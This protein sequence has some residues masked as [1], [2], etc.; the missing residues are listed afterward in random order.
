MAFKCE[1]VSVFHAFLFLCSAISLILGALAWSRN[2]SFHLP[3]PTS[4]PALATLLSPLTILALIATKLFIPANRNTSPLNL[5]RWRILSIVDQLH[6][7]ASTII[8]TIV[9]TYL[10]PNNIFSCHLEQQWQAFFQSRDAT[11]IRAIQD[12]FQCCGLRSIH[13]R[14][15]PFKDRNHGDNACEQQ[16]G[17]RQ[18][19]LLPWGEQQRVISW[20]V[21]TAAV[22]VWAVKVGFFLFDRRQ[23]SWM[24]T[25]SSRGA[26]EYQ[27]ITQPEEE[28]END[29]NGSAENGNGRI[30][31]PH[32]RP[33]ERTAYSNEWEQR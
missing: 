7:I 21:F 28:E 12:T 11:A 26:V 22:L 31:L 3:L 23:A 19:C 9:L 30:L 32:E 14:A 10:F 20:M 29:Q 27:R 4:L 24:S 6:S 17:Y 16:Y 1:A 13:D 5:Y 33:H 15:W 2:S 18:S 25:Q 8:A